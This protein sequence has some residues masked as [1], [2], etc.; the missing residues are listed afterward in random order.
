MKFPK[1]KEKSE[2]KANAKWAGWNR[3]A[4]SFASER[5][6][7]EKRQKKKDVLVLRITA[8]TEC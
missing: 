1:K 6:E 7:K 2:A 4:F 3:P 5:K 8:Q